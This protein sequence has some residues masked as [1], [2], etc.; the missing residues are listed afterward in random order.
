M[1]KVFTKISLIIAIACPF[2]FNAYAKIDSVLVRDN[3]FVPNILS[4]CQ[5]DTI[6]FVYDTGMVN[7]HDVHITNPIDSVSDT[8]TTAGDVFEFSPAVPNTYFYQCDFHTGMVGMFTVNSAPSVNLGADITQCGGTI[9]LDA[10]NAGLAFLWSDNSTTQTIT[11]FS[12][13]TFYVDVTNSNGCSSS[14]T[15]VCDIFSLPNVNLG[16]DV[17]LCGGTTLDAGNTGLTFNWSTGATTQTVTVSASGDYSVIITDANGCTDSDTVKVVASGQSPP[18]VEGFEDASFPPAGWTLNNPDGATQWDRTTATAKTG[19]ASIFIDNYG[20]SAVGQIDEIIS[21]ALDL[22]GG[23]ASASLTF[24]VAYQLYTDP[25]S[26]PNYSDTLKV[27]VSTDCGA[28]WST[29]YNKYGDSLTTTTPTYSTNPFIPTLIQWRQETVS[30]PMAS[31]LLVKFVNINDYQNRLYIDNINI[32]NGVGVN[33]ISLDNYISVFPNPSTGNVNVSISA[34][35]LGNVKMKLYN[36]L[37][38]K[39]SETTDNIS[40]PAKYQFDI[41]NQPSGIY[42]MEVTSEK[43]KTIKKVILNK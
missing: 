2:S 24:Y 21:P 8:L 10:G 35:G 7:N 4:I 39:I 40:V 1:K 19:I 32:N 20:D 26:N 41:S 38:D 34:F 37:G 11:A 43:E 25:S 12:S 18:L 3:A 30:L 33:D 15:V 31:K 27:Q 22:S 28:T 14:D 9:I 13:G 42:L 5:G 29:V 23:S 16:A 36:I 6:R 17:T